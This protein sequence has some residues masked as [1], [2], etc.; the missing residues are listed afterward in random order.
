MA[1]FAGAVGGGVRLDGLGGSEAAFEC[2]VLAAT[3]SAKVRLATWQ[4]IDLDT[5]VW[6]IPAARMKT[7]REH[8]VP[9]CSQAIQILQQARRL[10]V[11]PPAAVPADVV[12]PSRRTS[13]RLRGLFLPLPA[14]LPFSAD[15][16]ERGVV[17]MHGP[18]R[19]LGLV[20]AL[21]VRDAPRRGSFER[22]HGSF[23]GSAMSESAFRMPVTE[24]S[25]SSM[26]SSSAVV[27]ASYGGP[28]WLVSHAR[29]SSVTHP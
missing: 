15:H 4:E 8:R 3:R 2:L 5:M 28:P 22:P 6:T 7:A 29:P 1:R 24:E 18:I 23:G 17:S 26:R 25:A 12:F 27:P 19:R 21:A 9:L 20:E 13:P 10:R 16:P 14:T 11:D